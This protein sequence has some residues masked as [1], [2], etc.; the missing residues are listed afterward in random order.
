MK[1]Y[2]LLLAFA[3]VFASENVFPQVT[4]PVNGTTDPRHIISAFVNA[5]I[6][7]DYKTSIDSATLIVQDGRIVDVG[8]G[9]KAPADAVVYDLKGKFIYPSFIDIFSDYG[10]PEVSKPKHDD[11]GP[12]FFS[13]LKGAYGWNQAIHS[14]Y[15]AYKYFAVDS[16]KAEE[17]RK[18]GFGTVNSVDKDGIARGSSVLALLNEG[19]ENNSIVKREVQ[20]RIIPAR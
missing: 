13:N 15:D 5:K 20:C 14:D 6:F 16:K 8:K 11:G 10:L 18:L 1:R 2:L 17:L 3:A 12:Q 4:F 7:V 19:K 9:L